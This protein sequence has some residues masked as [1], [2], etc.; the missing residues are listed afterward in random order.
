MHADRSSSTSLPSWISMMS[1]LL[2]YI[3]KH[4]NLV[5]LEGKVKA[6]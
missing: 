5:V 4:L 1:S 6:N 2:L 3:V